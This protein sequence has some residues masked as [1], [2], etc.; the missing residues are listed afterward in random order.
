MENERYTLHTIRIL[1]EIKEEEVA[2]GERE[3]E[4]KNEN[5]YLWKFFKNFPFFTNF[6]KISTNSEF[7]QFLNKISKNFTNFLIFQHF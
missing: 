1:V 3:L 4:V 2:D 5:G 7:L 6:L